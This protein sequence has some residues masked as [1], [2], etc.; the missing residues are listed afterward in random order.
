MKSIQDLPEK[1][2]PDL[3]AQLDAANKRIAALEAALGPFAEI[4]QHWLDEVEPKHWATEIGYQ[5]TDGEFYTLY[6]NDEAPLRFLDMITAA[7][8]LKTGGRL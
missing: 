4:G 7:N 8:A 5:E 2:S 1:Q 6:L 3:Q